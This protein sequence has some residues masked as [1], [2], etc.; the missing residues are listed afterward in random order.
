MIPLDR[1]RR[2]GTR[3]QLVNRE[4]NEKATNQ[5]LGARSFPK[6]RQ[7]IL[8][9]SFQ[10]IFL[11]SAHK[12]N[13]ELSNSHA[14]QRTNLF[15]VRFSRT[16]QTEAINHFIGNEIRVAAVDFTMMKVIVL[17]AVA[18][19]R[20]QSGRKILGLV[21]RT[22]IDNVVRHQRR[23]PAHSFPSHFK[24]VG[25]PDRSSGHNLD[26]A[27]I[28]SRSLSALPDESNAPLDQVGIG[29]LQ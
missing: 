11:I 13:V 8:L 21:A 19:I 9:I 26:V 29:E 24:I 7:H 14:S 27:R 17:P 15:N 16:K 3:Y 2:G 5:Q 23:K 12:I 25:N 6:N 4:P 18:Y 1:V 28:P 20:G 10:R 22:Q